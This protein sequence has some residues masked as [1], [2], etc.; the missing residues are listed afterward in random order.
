MYMRHEYHVNRNSS[1]AKPIKTERKRDIKKE[2]DKKKEWR[3]EGTKAEKVKDRKKG[4]TNDTKK[5]LYSKE[6]M[7]VTIAT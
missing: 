6:K 4:R 3:K 2:R 1:M 7:K 5:E